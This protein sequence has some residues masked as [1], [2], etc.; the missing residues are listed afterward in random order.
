[1]REEI[2]LVQQKARKACST[3]TAE[4]VVEGEFE[5]ESCR[6]AETTYQ[7]LFFF[8]NKE[9]YILVLIEVDKK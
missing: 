3:G 1:M 7:D 6:S 5:S 2:K 8:S 4:T 9:N